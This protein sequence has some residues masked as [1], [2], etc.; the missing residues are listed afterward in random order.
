MFDFKNSGSIRWLAIAAT[1]WLSA[2]AA[3]AG[4]K[5]PPLP[6][7][8]S[9]KQLVSDKLIARIRGEM[10]REIVQLSVKSQNIRHKDFSEADILA[11]DKKWRAERK[12]DD[13]P[14][15]AASLTRPL[16]TYLL[17]LQA[18]AGGLY[19][20][21]FI[22]DDKGLNAGQSTIT[23][24]YWQGDEGKWK[25]TFLAGSDAIFIDEAEWHEGSKTWRAQVNIAIADAKSSK[26]IGAAT[27]EI[28]L[29]ELS[30]RAG[31]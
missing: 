23:S 27:F 2:G 1:L 14:L 30:R 17:K 11:L 8:M 13:K 4:E 12:S 24:D 15:I 9:P 25:K 16:S 6:P 26:P 29:T 22:M 19:T 5:A 7:G 28:N 10:G 31:V 20:E 3:D 21:I 18:H